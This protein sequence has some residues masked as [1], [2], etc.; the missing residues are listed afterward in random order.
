[1]LVFDV[2]HSDGDGLAAKIWSGGGGEPDAEVAVG[3]ASPYRDITPVGLA[4]RVDVIDLF[5]DDD[6]FGLSDELAVEGQGRLV[7]QC[8]KALHSLVDDGVV[9]LFVAPAL[10]GRAG[11]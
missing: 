3:S 10:G 2:L 9:E 5:L 11:S 7:G 4:L 1:M 6:A 8:L